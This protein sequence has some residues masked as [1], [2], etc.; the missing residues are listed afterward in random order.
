MKLSAI[1]ITKN[2]EANIA[3]CLSSVSFADEIIVVDAESTDATASLAR[4]A[5]ATVFVRPWPGYGPQKNFGASCAHGEW[6]LFIDADEEVPPALAEEIQQTIVNPTVDFYWL[7]IVTVFVGQPLRHLYGHNPRLFKKSA[8]QWTEDHVHEQVQH[9]ARADEYL[10]VKLDDRFSKMLTA[11]LLHHSHAT[12][13]SYLKKMHRYTSL[14]AEQMKKTGRHR[15]GR[16]VKPSFL[17]PWRLAIRQSLKLALY[18]RGIL[19]GGP[20][21]LWCAL[22]G[23]YEYEMATKFLELRNLENIRDKKQDTNV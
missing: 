1:V 6:L 12:I 8:G 17:L 5:G 15:S 21:I 22:S 10:V 4:E 2:E 23:Y 19:D 18:R 20:G 3:R 14:D 9:S 16:P 7:R 11:S 13:A